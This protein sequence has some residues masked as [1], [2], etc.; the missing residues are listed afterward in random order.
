MIVV[1]KVILWY[2]L[3]RG[4]MWLGAKMY[5]DKDPF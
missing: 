3:A 4:F 2:I 5:Q 1:I